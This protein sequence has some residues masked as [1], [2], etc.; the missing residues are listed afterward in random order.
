MSIRWAAQELAARMGK[1]VTFTGTESETALLNNASKSHQ[2]FGYPKVS[3]LQMLDWTA[4]WV[5]SGGESWNKPT[6]FQERKGNSNERT[7]SC[8]AEIGPEKLKALHEG[9]VI[10]AHPLALDENRKLDERH[11][12]ALTRYYAAS[13]AGGVAVGVH[14]THSRS[15]IKASTCMNRCCGSQRKRSV[16]RSL[17]GLS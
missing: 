1:E 4:A 8:N 13:G 7:G 11:Q 17:T 2:L 16:R 14:S 10:P 5:Q 3:L 15:A 6:H 12:R 9:L